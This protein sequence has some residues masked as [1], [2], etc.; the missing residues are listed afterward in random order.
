MHAFAAEP[1]NLSE[2]GKEC[3]RGAKLFR[4]AV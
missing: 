4:E 3:I 1:E 2:F